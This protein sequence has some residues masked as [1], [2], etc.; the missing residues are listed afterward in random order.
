MNDSLNRQ[1]TGGGE[2]AGRLIRESAEIAAREPLL[3][4]L[5]RRRIGETQD[6]PAILSRMLAAELEQTEMP[7]RVL[8]HLFRTLFSQH[9]ELERY[10]IADIDAVLRRDPA[11]RSPLAVVLDHKGFTSL[12]CHRAIHS[13]WNA[14]RTELARGLQS[15]VAR[16]LA[17]DIHPACRIGIGVML[18]HASGIVIGETATVGD[19]VS[20]MQAVTLGGTGKDAGDRHPKV[21]DGVLLGAGAIL[22]GAITIGRNARIGAGSVVLVDV[23][24]YATAV[25]IP[26]TIRKG[27]P[28]TH[29]QVAAPAESMTQCW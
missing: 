28:P 20:I 8:L 10:A 12:L 3:R 26:A 16:K 1:E 17:V 13:L 11:T 4:N 15:V 14:G 7:Y 18:D 23:P 22:L 21:G 25:G 29:Q 24:A 2:L 9:S 5:L 6:L 19:N 27:N